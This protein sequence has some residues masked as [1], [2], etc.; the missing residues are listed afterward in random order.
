MTGIAKIR[1]S[2]YA[3]QLLRANCHGVYSKKSTV[4]HTTGDVMR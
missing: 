3:L 2:N 4:E 1:N